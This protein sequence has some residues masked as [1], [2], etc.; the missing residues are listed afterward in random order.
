MGDADLERNQFLRNLKGELLF[1]TKT[2]N[3]PIPLDELEQWTKF[4][5]AMLPNHTHHVRNLLAHSGREGW[6]WLTNEHEEPR[7]LKHT[8]AGLKANLKEHVNVI[9]NVNQLK[10]ELTE[11]NCGQKTINAILRNTK[12]TSLK[13]V[14]ENPYVIASIENVDFED[15]DRMAIATHRFTADDPRRLAG[16]VAY[17]IA[18]DQRFGNTFMAKEMTMDSETNLL[19]PRNTPTL[20][21]KVS[22][23]LLGNKL[24]PELQRE[25]KKTTE[26]KIVSQITDTIFKKAMEAAAEFNIDDN[27]HKLFQYHVKYGFVYIPLHWNEIHLAQSL[28]RLRSR[29]A[30]GQMIE[31]SRDKAM[32]FLE[33]NF[34]EF[35]PV[36]RTA[37]LTMLDEPVTIL[38]GGPGTGKT[39]AIVAGVGVFIDQGVTNIAIAATTGMAT[40]NI[41]KALV[42]RG[43]LTD[44]IIP[45]TAHKMLS[46]RPETE[47][48][49][50]SHRYN[51]IPY[52]VIFCDEFSMADTFL[53]STLFWA[54]A[55]GTRIIIVGDPYQ[56]PSVGPGNVLRD[57][58]RGLRKLKDDN[59]ERLLKEV[60]CP[61]WICLEKCY[62]HDQEIAKLAASLWKKLDEREIA[63]REALDVGEASGKIT[64][65]TYSTES[66]ILKRVVKIAR[67]NDNNESIIF[68]APRYE[69]KLGVHV[70][71][72]SVR[73]VINPDGELVSNYRVGDLILQKVPDNPNGIFNGEIGVVSHTYAYRGENSPASITVEFQPQDEGGPARSV[74]HIGEA[75]DRYWTLGYVT[76]VHKNQGGQAD[77]AVCVI[78]KEGWDRQKLYTAMTRAKK[79]LIL[80]EMEGGIEKAL[81]NRYFTRRTRLPRRY[82]NA[83]KKPENKIVS[84]L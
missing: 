34:P 14:K 41:R 80:L 55:N 22:S 33:L 17:A 81:N 6:L 35:D 58:T 45:R 31:T 16:A 56:L 42:R 7:L 72:E 4:Y 1:V 71:N 51:P 62:R 75:I 36:Q 73:E 23:L 27:G 66:D 2:K 84:N 12:S 69:D 59:K 47:R 53:A 30:R 44:K 20:R 11:M 61:A 64:R 50:Y 77:T 67:D 63:F 3:K 21:G 32:S 29:S 68:M 83:V 5:E 48:C 39:E 52:D 57:L 49:L 76:T 74:T 9:Q 28:V 60:D 26:N 43:M 79:H 24:F 18:S 70:L 19:R 25:F 13:K 37:V 15:L 8:D 38:T 82:A 54:T 40:Q 65:I 78:G 46:L 10:K